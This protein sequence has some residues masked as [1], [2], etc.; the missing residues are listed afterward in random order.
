VVSSS[1]PL[2]RTSLRQE[3]VVS[4]P[5]NVLI[6]LEK[7]LADVWSSY[8]ESE[9]STLRQNREDYLLYASI[10]SRHRLGCH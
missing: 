4:T 3:L 5:A 10:H 8:G 6:T 1:T 9:F 2:A 7:C